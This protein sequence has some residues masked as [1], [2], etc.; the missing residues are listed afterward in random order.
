VA[1]QWVAQKISAFGGSPD[2]ITVGGQSAGGVSVHAQVLE[3]KS[4]QGKPLF[5]R[6]IIQSGAVG[7]VGP[8]SMDEADQRWRGLC[9][10]LQIAEKIPEERIDFLRDMTDSDLV[11]VA[12]EMGW[13]SLPLVED[14]KTLTKIA[15]GSWRFF[16]GPQ[17]DTA[18]QTA[19]VG[20]IEVL[21]GDC[22]GEVRNFLLTYSNLRSILV[23]HERVLLYFDRHVLTVSCFPGYDLV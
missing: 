10:Y 23:I 12:G 19:N 3:A 15:D 11:R 6:A 13:F 2:R 18:S 4:N 22:D 1:L 17:S 21:I 16:L 5:Q 20:P 8:I 14:D 7:T 9:Q